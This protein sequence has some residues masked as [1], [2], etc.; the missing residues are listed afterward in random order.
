[1]QAWEEKVLEQ[2]KAQEEGRLE[3]QRKGIHIF[4]S[5][6]LAERVS[7]D[8]ILAKLQKNYGLTL[9]QAEEYYRE[10]AD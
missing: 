2:Q 10:V 6:F 9:E 4:I 5:E 7:S 3:E 8:K 1:M